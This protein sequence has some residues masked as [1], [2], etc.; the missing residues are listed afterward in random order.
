MRLFLPHFLTAVFVVAGA[1]CDRSQEEA[2]GAPNTSLVE[3]D[4]PLLA[5]TPGDEWVYQVDLEIPAGATSWGSAEVE[6]RYDRVRRCLGKVSAAKGLPAV[7]CFEVVVPGFPTERE[8]VE[9]RPDS[10]LMRGSMILREETTLPMWLNQPVPFVTAGLAVGDELP[11][12]SAPEGGLFR[13]TRV[14]A[15]EEVT[16]PAGQFSCIRLLTT[17][18]D[19]GIDLR[20][21]VWFSPGTGIVREEKTRHRDGQLLFRE[22]Q[23]LSTVRLAD[24]GR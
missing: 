19:G 21:S 8:F 17:G 13:Q 2:A 12:V 6:Q 14:M 22:I 7:D 24:G 23:Q 1:A 18:R 16:V 9:I 3:E 4:T 15:R 20:Q 10:I 5:V 11:A